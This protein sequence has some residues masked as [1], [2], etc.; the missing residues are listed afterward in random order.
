MS[1]Y[2]VFKEV[3]LS[4]FCQDLLSFLVGDNSAGNLDACNLHRR[5]A[6]QE[7]SSEPPVKVQA[8]SVAI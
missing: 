5:S 3:H 4:G 6:H 1:T 2:G 7:P 8:M